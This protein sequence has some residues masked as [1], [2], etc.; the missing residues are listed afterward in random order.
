[1]GRDAGADLAGRELGY[2]VQV[3]ASLAYEF[4][5]TLCAMG[6]PE[7]QPT[8][9]VGQSWFDNI[10]TTASPSLQSALHRVGD[11][12][13]KVWVNLMGLA[14]RS[15]AAPDAQS[16]LQLVGAL[17]LRLATRRGEV[18]PSRQIRHRLG[19]RVARQELRG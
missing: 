14:T 11:N 8:Y 1:M 12:V 3:D 2:R 17:E 19:G 10:R 5:I 4:L 18:E 16:L 13:G 9:E 15:P 6:N 7:E